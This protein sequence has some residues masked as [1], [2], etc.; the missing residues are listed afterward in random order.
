MCPRI[1]TEKEKVTR[2][3]RKISFFL[4]LIMLGLTIFIC[5]TGRS[6]FGGME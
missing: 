5:Q 2:A 3:S 6:I 4:F 1:P